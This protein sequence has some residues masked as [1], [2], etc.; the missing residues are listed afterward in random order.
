MTQNENRPLKIAVLLGSTRPGRRGADIARWVHAAA[1]Q[2]SAATYEVV[3][4]LDHPLP[5]LDEELPP[6]VGA[7]ARPHTR[8][9]AET[10]AQYDAFVVVTPEYNHSVPAVL[11]N[12]IDFLYAEWND[13][14]AGVVAYGAE[15]GTRAVEH[16][17]QVFGEL[18]VAVVRQHVA[19]SLYD[20]FEDFERFAPRPQLADYLGTLFDQVE[21]WGGALRDVRASRARESAD[22]AVA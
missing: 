19:I 14:V 5:F 16:L 12:A 6:I 20:D 21:S 7:Y 10:I 15:S 13:K 17:R 8:A 22:D 11:K 18:Q 3:D 2:R 1:E 4:L 9:W